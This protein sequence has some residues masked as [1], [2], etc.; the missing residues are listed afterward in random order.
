MLGEK[1]SKHLAILFDVLAAIADHSGDRFD[2]AEKI[3]VSPQVIG[4]Q[5]KLLRERFGMTIK[6]STKHGYSIED[7]GIIDQRK[8]EALR[9]NTNG[10]EPTKS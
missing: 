9:E 3:G 10:T 1:N 6:S 2:L 8:F 5:V 7:W 4:R